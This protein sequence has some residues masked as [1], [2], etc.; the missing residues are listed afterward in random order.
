[1]SLEANGQT[2][3]D[4]Q[5]EEPDEVAANDSRENESDA[6]WTDGVHHPGTEPDVEGLVRIF[7]DESA[8]GAGR[9]G[10]MGETAAAEH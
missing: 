1:L 10:W 8:Q 4:P 3:Q 2:N 5:G 6:K 7:P 9:G